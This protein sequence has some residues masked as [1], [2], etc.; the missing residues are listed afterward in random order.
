MCIVVSVSS[1]CKGMHA[2]VILS[3]ETC[4]DQPSIASHHMVL[5]L[6]GAYRAYI[7]RATPEQACCPLASCTSTSQPQTISH[8]FLEC[9]VAATVVSW[10]CRLW[11]A[12]T[13][14]LPEASV[15]TV[16]ANQKHGTTIISAF[17][18]FFFFWVTGEMSIPIRLACWKCENTYTVQSSHSRTFCRS[19]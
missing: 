17:F 8:L 2:W 4:T 11:Q 7:H 14:H 12:M 1:C 18:F 16:L 3:F 10:L 6:C 5:P 13:G 9:P 15:A 19:V